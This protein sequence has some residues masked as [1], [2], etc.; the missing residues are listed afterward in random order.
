MALLHKKSGAEQKI[1]SDEQD[2]VM[3]NINYLQ[4][5]NSKESV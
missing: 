4:A 3:Q 2:S 5:E 1:K